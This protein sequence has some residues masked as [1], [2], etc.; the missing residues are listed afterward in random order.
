MVGI[1]VRLV[2]L[3]PMRV[4]GVRAV[5]RTPERDAWQAL[6]AWAGPRGLLNDPQAHPVFGFNNP[7]PSPGCGE[8]GYELWIRIEP[9]RPT[10]GEVVAKDFPGGL[11]AVTGCRLCG[12]IGVPQVWKRLWDWAQAGSHKW[13][14][15]HE[16]EL[17]RIPEAAEEEMILDLYLPVE[18]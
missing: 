12:E 9:D 5:S 7:N 15:T 8:Y 16:L 3:E 4:A 2:R 10:E 11:Y 17:L 18:E 6:R 13:R 14:W 1:D